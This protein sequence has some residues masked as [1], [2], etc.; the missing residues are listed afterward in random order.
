MRA[1]PTPVRFANHLSPDRRGRGN[2]GRKL[3]ALPLPH[4]VGGEVAAKR[5]EWGIFAICDSPAVNGEKDAFTQ[6]FASLQRCRSGTFVAASKLL[7]VLD[8][9]KVPAGA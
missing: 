6:D 4:C 2:A 7:R 3:G 1:T 5:T 8:G 9:E